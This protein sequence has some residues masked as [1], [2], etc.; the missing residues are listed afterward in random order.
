MIR[1]SYTAAVE[2]DQTWRGPFQS[3]P[4]EAGWAS[5]AI[6]YIRALEAKNVPAGLTAQVQISPD[7][8]HWCDEGTK[9][10]LPVGPDQVTFGRVSRFGGWLRLNGELPAGAQLQ[11]IVYLSLKE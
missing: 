7:G 9:V 10:T 2:R 5:E 4:Y 6:F 1:Q 11:V 3:E 8:M